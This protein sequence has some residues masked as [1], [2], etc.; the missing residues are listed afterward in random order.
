MTTQPAAESDVVGTEPLQ[1]YRVADLAGAMG[2]YCTKLLADLG[3]DVI[4]VEPPG[5]DANA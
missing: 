2:A 3:A 1:G 4:T 5:G